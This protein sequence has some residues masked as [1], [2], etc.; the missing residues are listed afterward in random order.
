[1]NIR[2]LNS[3][4]EIRRK[5]GE[6]ALL[7]NDAQGMQRFIDIKDLGNHQISVNGQNLLA[8]KR[9][10]QG[11][12]YDIIRYQNKYRTGTNFYS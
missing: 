10:R 3:T 6:I 4:G 5:Q 2:A 7:W 9:Q 12:H 1:V 8:N 11:R